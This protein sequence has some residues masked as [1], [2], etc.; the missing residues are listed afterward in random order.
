MKK[1]MKR[2]KKQSDKMELTFPDIER[3]TGVD[4]VVITD[5][6]SGKTSEMKFDNFLPVVTV[7][8][9]NMEERKEIINEFIMLCMGDLNIR[10]ALCYCQGIGE[11]E[12]IDKIIKKHKNHKKL[13]K[14]FKIYQLY[15]FRNINKI[16]GQAMID[17]M[18]EISF[19][20]DSEIQ[21]LVNMLYSFSMYDI[22]NYRAMLPYTDKVE[23]NLNE[24]NKGFIK[25]CLEMHYNDRIA[26]INLFNEDVKACR[27]KCE[28]ILNSDIDVPVIKA[29][30]LCCLGE[31]FLFTD[32]LKAEKYLLESIKYLVDNGIS[33]NGRKYKSFQST[34]AFLYIDNGFNLD[35]IDFTCIDLSEI[36]Y[37]E[38]LYGNK[39]KA[40][41]M[42]EKLSRERKFVSPFIM[43]YISRINNDILGLKEALKRFERVGN[44]HY[45]NAVKRVLASIEKRVG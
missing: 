14:Y 21:V 9:E 26:Y 28:E 3:K 38:G 39:E 6:V 33:K 36:A 22:F 1:L 25:S 29:T 16:R 17:K 12:T 11:Y 35:K 37:Y 23:K 40:L 34:L 2:I 32:V 20:N 18:D 8:F 15:N 4:R 42:F 43:Y 13:Q 44:Y 30:A 5:A 31:S 41:K 24:L 27:K 45:A 10:K 19:S 7:L